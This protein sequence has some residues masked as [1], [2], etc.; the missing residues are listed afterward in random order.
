MRKKR[1]KRQRRPWHGVWG[2][3]PDCA[4]L[5]GI[6]PDQDTWDEIRCRIIWGSNEWPMVA[7]RQLIATDQRQKIAPFMRKL[8]ADCERAA[9]EG[10]ADWFR[11]QANAIEKGGS[12]ERTQFNAKVVYCL[13]HAMCET[14]GRPENWRPLT[15]A[16]RQGFPNLRRVPQVI[17]LTPAGK[18]T[19]KMAS[20]IYKALEKRPVQAGDLSA[21]APDYE[22]R[23]AQSKEQRK[24][25]GEAQ[26]KES[27]EGLLM[28]GC[29]FATKEDVMKAIHDL[30][31]RLQFE[32]KKQAR[33]RTREKSFGKMS[34]SAYAKRL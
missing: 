1:K 31:T 26:I 18:F 16:E 9:L 29:Y 14:L 10:D 11:R 13:E 4:V 2:R 5:S 34:N 19:D 27:E 7:V 17:T 28:E 8:I 20:D 12:P 22:Q 24:A 15:N 25:W 30:A 23:K 6:K 32:L 21:V 33:K 3:K